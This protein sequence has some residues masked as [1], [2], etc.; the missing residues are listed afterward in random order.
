[1]GNFVYD[2]ILLE[3]DRI[4]SHRMQNVDLYYKDVNGSFEKLAEAYDPEILEL[5]KDVFKRKRTSFSIL[6]N[7]AMDGYTELTVSE[8][9]MLNFLVKT[10]N[11]GN[12]VNGYTIRDFRSCMGMKTEVITRVLKSLCAKGYIK[13]TVYRAKRTYMVNPSV[14]YRGS[15]KRLAY[16]TKSYDRMKSEH[17]GKKYVKKKDVPDIFD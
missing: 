16:A 10:M 1:M 9:R 2:L 5:L 7:D 12:L 4:M 13:Y 6:F 8:K 15:L 3:A 14:F 11:Y 17:I